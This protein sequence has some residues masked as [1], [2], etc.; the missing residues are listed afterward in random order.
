MTQWTIA[1]RLRAT[2]AVIIL[3][4]VGSLVLVWWL[5]RRLQET[6]TAADARHEQVMVSAV[7]LRY[8][9]QEMRDA[10]RR[11][12]E[13]AGSQDVQGEVARK[14][15][16]DVEVDKILGV[17][18]AMAEQ[19][20]GLSQPLKEIKEFDA[21]TL[22]PLED[23]LVEMAKATP[24][25]GKDFYL[26]KYVP[27]LTA[28]DALI[29]GAERQTQ[30]LGE[31][32][33]KRGNT[34]EIVLLAVIA[35]IVA[36][37]VVASRQ[38][39]RAITGPLTQL[40]QAMETLRAGNLTRRLTLPR[41]DEFGVL[42]EG[43]NGTADRLAELIGQIQKTGIQVNSSVTEMA[44]TLKEQQ[45]SANEVASTTMEIGATAKE[46]TANAKELGKTVGEVATVS[47]HT[48]HLADSGHSGLSQLEGTMR[49]I[50]GAAATISAK[51]AILNE[52]TGNI[53]AVVTTINKVADQT[54]LLSLNA[55]IEAEKAG[56]YGQGFA[57]VATE[58]RRLADQTAVATYDIEQMVK[59]M[60]SAV[61]AGV[62]GMDKFNEEVRKG[63]DEVRQVTG[64]LGEIIQQVQALTPRFEAVNEGMQTQATAASQIS[65]ALGQLSETTQQSAQ[66]GRQNAEAIDLLSSASH[67]LQEAVSRFTV[68]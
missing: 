20:P 47:T 36:V 37:S 43:L 7:R 26:Q 6:Q 29:A 46:I 66:A 60:Q 65:D 9:Y 23:Q 22:S 55:A 24:A 18:A 52:K 15:A 44:A 50:L 64:Q 3:L 5:E 28:M 67:G 58:I 11:I 40:L 38:M 2:L 49:Q 45:A 56:E 42:A 14:K 53:N 12:A 13:S 39:T 68:S 17:M 31:Q 10:T 25:T 59:E 41:R 30:L 4:L 63:G 16:A 54:N 48:A 21:R 1:Q 34:V 19:Y 27:E 33:R 57:V 32:D 61:A 51:L 62:M 35:V 8:M